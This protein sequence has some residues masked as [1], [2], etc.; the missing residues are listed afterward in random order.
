MRAGMINKYISNDVLELP[1]FWTLSDDIG[2]LNAY[3]LYSVLCPEFFSGD[4]TAEKYLKQE[5]ESMDE[6]LE[7]VMAIQ[8][9]R[10]QE[11]P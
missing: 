9:K 4:Y 3:R 11:Q 2:L 7:Q 1:D 5:E 8:A 10:N 6:L